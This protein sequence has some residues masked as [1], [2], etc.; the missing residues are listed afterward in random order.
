LDDEIFR[1]WCD[2]LIACQDN[3][4][5][6]DTLLPVVSK[7]TDVRIVNNELQG[8]LAAARNEYWV[9]VAL[10]VGNIPLLYLLNK[11]WYHTLIYETA[12]KVVLGICGVV[13]LVTALF[14]MKFTKP[15][16]YKR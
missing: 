8:M 14:M 15:I 2:T 3:R 1:E 9:M 13:I 5:L 4:T 12:G 16:E 10:V 7:L 11:D 6:K